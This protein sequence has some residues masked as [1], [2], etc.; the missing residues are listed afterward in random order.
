MPST[1]KNLFHNTLFLLSNL[2]FPLISFS[3]AS[4][5]LGPA[6]Y[7]K[8]QLVLVF[9]QYFVLVAALGIPLFGVRE[10][11]KIRNDQNKLSKMVSEL[12]VINIISSVGA[13]IIYLITIYS[14][15]WFHNDLQLYLLGGVIVLSGFSTLDWFY[16]GMEQFQFL[17]IR[18]IVIK[19]LALL[20]LFI[21]VKTKDDLILY[22]FVV[23]F[24][25]LGNNLWNLIGIR[26]LLHYKINELCFRQH[27]PALAT[28]LGTTVS[29]SVYTVIDT[30]LL[31]LITDNTAVGYY[32]AAV[33]INKIAI[34]IV[35]VLGTVLIPRITQSMANKDNKQLNVLVNQSFSFICLIGIPITFGLFI[36]AKEFIVSISGFEFISASTTM[37][38]T[39]P[40]A[41]LIGLGHLFGFQLLIPAGLEKKYLF[42]TIAGMLI[43][44]VL[45]LILVSSIKDKGT[46][47]AT[48]SGEFV[49]SLVSY[50]FVYRNINLTINWLQAIKAI[51]SSIFFLPIAYL[52]RPIIANPI[53]VLLIAIPSS[54]LVYFTVQTKIFKNEMLK[55]AWLVLKQKTESFT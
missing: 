33:K 5:V 48:L 26:K 36:F 11:A 35:T 10:I 21:F 3:Y 37:Q 39:A 2:L 12:L 7:G 41:L 27:I 22:F 13:L 38:I 25:I 18:S 40:L 1:K 8:I 46:A 4:H 52:L 54:A 29:I 45:N 17:S 50:Y 43:S 28:L 30:L 14:V 42:A 23:L 34:P 55:E 49:V 53:V 9:A 20:A 24:S 31:G 51:V 44:I 19:A 32:S 16:N 15:S 47:I 6:A